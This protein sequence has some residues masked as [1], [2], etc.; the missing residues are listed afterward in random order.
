MTNTSTFGNYFHLFLN[1]IKSLTG[2]CLTIIH[3]YVKHFVVKQQF[4]QA[5]IF[6]TKC[7]CAQYFG[8]HIILDTRL[9]ILYYCYKV[10]SCGLKGQINS[11]VTNIIQI[12]LTFC[13]FDL[14]RSTILINSTCIFGVNLYDFPWIRPPHYQNIS[15]GYY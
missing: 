13:N 9:Y 14:V 2:Y 8:H 12:D 5:K 6:S 10:G 3:W 15:N 1:K 4:C 7:V 11:R